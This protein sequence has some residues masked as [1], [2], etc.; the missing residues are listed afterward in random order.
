MELGDFVAQLLEILTRLLQRLVL[1]LRAAAE[2]VDLRQSLAER[3]ERA[4]LPRHLVGLGHQGLER[5]AQLVGA[6]V[7]RRQL[8]VLGEH[9]VHARFRFGHRAGQRP[10]AMVE[11]IELLTIDRKAL[12]SAS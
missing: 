12:H 9:A 5:L 2:L 11:L 4:L 7:H 10:Q 6:L 8:L 3:F 1:R